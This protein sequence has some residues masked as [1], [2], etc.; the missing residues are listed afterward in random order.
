MPVP[1]VSLAVLLL[2]VAGTFAIAF[3]KSG[4]DP[5]KWLL[6]ETG[7]YALCFLVATLGVSPV[8]RAVRKP[9]LVLWRRP[10]GLAGFFVASAH[11]V[12]Y[13]TVYQ[14]LLFAAIMEDIAKRPY[15][16]VGLLAWLM[17]IPLAATSTRYARRRM[18]PAWARLHRTVYVIVPI[19]VVHQ[20]MA[21]KADM[22]QTLLF[23][24]ITGCFLIERVVRAHR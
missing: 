2:A 4:P 19:A 24:A 21:Q 15:I 1:V 6:H 9:I 16:L 3:G 14:G 18:G 10:L 13:A 12:V 7:F 17:L 23:L 8:A 22:G 20:G 11:V 5:A